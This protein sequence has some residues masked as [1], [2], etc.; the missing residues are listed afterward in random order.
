M[1][2]FM[3]SSST[4]DMVGLDGNYYID[5]DNKKIWL[6]EFGEL[7]SKGINAEYLH[8]LISDSIGVTD[9]DTLDHPILAKVTVGCYEFRNDWSFGDIKTISLV[10]YGGFLTESTS[11]PSLSIT[12]CIVTLD[13]LNENA[14]TYYKECDGSRIIKFDSKGT[15]NNNVVVYDVDENGEVITDIRSSFILG[16]VL[17]GKTHEITLKDIGINKLQHGVY[18][19]PLSN[20]DFY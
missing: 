4:S 10:K 19:Y 9:Y 14:Q 17:N 16:G 18:Y 20:R 1:N 5:N 15:I 7:T 12:A 13:N 11:T 6:A 3:K 2:E 8:T